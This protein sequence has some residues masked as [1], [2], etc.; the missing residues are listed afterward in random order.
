[1]TRRKG[2]RTNNTS[3]SSESEWI[4]EEVV[5]KRVT[6]E[7]RVE[8]LLH[9]KDWSEST[10][11]PEEHLSCFELISKFEEKIKKSGK[12]TESNGTEVLVDK[13]NT[14]L[15]EKIGV[16]NV[17]SSNSSVSD[18]AMRNPPSSKKNQPKQN[19]AG[20]D[21]IMHTID[22]SLVPDKVIGVVNNSSEGLLVKMKWKNKEEKDL[23]PSS[24][25][26]T[27][28]PQLVINYYQQRI[29]WQET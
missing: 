8:Y 19:K 2:K 10:W 13:P 22:K 16:D 21:K 11:E 26:N 7:G 24:I 14:A 3:Q 28:W 9:W 12:S 29:R 4:V 27:T 6:E 1:M 23:I 20:S 17:M 18:D 5:D 15:N 25:A